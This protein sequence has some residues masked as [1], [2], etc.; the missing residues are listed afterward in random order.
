VSSSISRQLIF[1]LAVPLMLLALCGAL[2]HYFNNVAPGVINSDRRLRDA[3]GALM[4]RLTVEEGRVR[5]DG[6]SRG[7]PPLPPP[8]SIAFAVRD[9]QGRLLLGDGRLPVV[10]MTDAT[11]QV[12]ALA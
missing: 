4:A 5:L 12:F 6:D 9:A 3:A 1:W 7:K 11:A 10:A 8:D 2:V